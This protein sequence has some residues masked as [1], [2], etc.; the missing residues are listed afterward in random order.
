MLGPV[1][2]EVTGYRLHDRGIVVQLPGRARMFSS[3]RPNQ[4]WHTSKLLASRYG[5]CF[6]Q[7]LK[8]L[9]PEADICISKQ[10]NSFLLVYGHISIQT[11]E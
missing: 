6:S 3:Q 5:G 2:R 1:Q 7:Q 8:W 10:H 4:L 9:G 11:G